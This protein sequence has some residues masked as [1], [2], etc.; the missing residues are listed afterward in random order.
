MIS[1][2]IFIFS[3][4]TIL[5]HYSDKNRPSSVVV[6]WLVHTADADKTKMAV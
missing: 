3:L 1:D 6:L 5:H 2:Y 4:F